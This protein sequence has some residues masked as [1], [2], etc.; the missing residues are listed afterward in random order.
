MKTIQGKKVCYARADDW[1]YEEVVEWRASTDKSG[2]CQSDEV[3]CGGDKSSTTKYCAEKET[4]DDNNSKCPI[5]N[6]E[7]ISK[8]IST[9]SSNNN[10]GNSGNSNTGPFY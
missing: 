1:D 9:Y 7:Y 5:N 6:F 10:N 3:L 8:D 2:T 4:Y